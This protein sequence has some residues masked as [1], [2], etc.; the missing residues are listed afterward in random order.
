MQCANISLRPPP[1]VH[2]SALGPFVR[3]VFSINPSY[4]GPTTIIFARIHCGKAEAGRQTY[5]FREGDELEK[6]M[7]SEKHEQYSRFRY[8]AMLFA[9]AA[10]VVAPAHA[11]GPLEKVIYSFQGG[12]D[13]IQ[14]EGGLIADRNGNLYGT[15]QVGNGLNGCI[16]GCGTVFELSPPSVPGGSWTETILYRFQ[17]GDDDGAAPSGSLLMDASGNLYGVTAGTTNSGTVFELSPPVSEG[18]AW[19]EKIL[20]LFPPTDTSKGADPYGDLVFDRKGNLYG[21]ASGGTHLCPV[22]EANG[23]CGVVFE[24]SPS[25]DTS[26]RWQEKV[27]HNFSRHETDGFQPRAGLAVDRD[28]TLYGTTFYGGL[29]GGGTVFQMKRVLGEWQETILYNFDP[30]GG[31]FPQAP[32]KLDNAG[33]LFGTATD[34]SLNGCVG[35]ACGAVFELS[36]PQTEGG[37]WSIAF[38]YTFSGARDGGNPIRGR[39]LQDQA[40]NIYG[41]TELG[42]L[43]NNFTRNN[44]T[45]FKLSP[46]I[47]AGDPWIESTLHEFSGSHYNDGGQPLASLVF[48]KGKFYG[49]TSSGGTRNLGTIF[50]LTIVP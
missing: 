36:P 48:V 1:G 9:L 24:L 11:S 5:S 43:K 2:T 15:T 42:G 16:S 49:T 34:A 35:S 23:G 13:G 17:A 20:Y 41:T 44:G 29:N 31:A 40:G 50:S 4:E 38:L 25:T 39:L 12:N 37:A 7:K 46:P 22:G 3:F 47:V 8:T 10:I 18:G 27:L 19:T 14:P 45:I 26:A 6:E 28:G 21:T 30:S 32:L 33:R